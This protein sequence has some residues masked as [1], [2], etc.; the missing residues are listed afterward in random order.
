[1]ENN[2]LAK[3]E[4]EIQTLSND[5]LVAALKGDIDVLRLIHEELADRGHSAKTGEWIGF[6]AAQDELFDRWHDQEIRW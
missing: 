6:A 4:Q 3:A 1:M 2:I 5:V